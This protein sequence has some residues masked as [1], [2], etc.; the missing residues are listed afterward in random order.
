MIIWGKVETLREQRSKLERL[1]SAEPDFG[2]PPETL[3]TQGNDTESQF[4]PDYLFVDAQCGHE[5]AFEDIEWVVNMGRMDSPPQSIETLNEWNQSLALFLEYEG[6]VVGPENVR[7][8][9]ATATN[10]APNHPRVTEVA[11]ANSTGTRFFAVA[12]D[13]ALEHYLSWRASTSGE[14]GAPRPKK[15]LALVEPDVFV[16]THEFLRFLACFDAHRALALAAPRNRTHTDTGFLVLT[17]PAADLVGR[18]ASSHRLPT[19]SDAPGHALVRWCRHAGVALK[20]V[21]LVVSDT[22]PDVWLGAHVA[23]QIARGLRLPVVY[24]HVPLPQQLDYF[25][26]YVNFERGRHPHS[27]VYPKVHQQQSQ[28]Q[29]Q[30]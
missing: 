9:W 11:V 14:N 13:S 28:Q 12:A 23:D 17:Q 22:P 1:V 5:V 10:P 8:V 15:W 24:T 25:P 29:Q 21:A 2:M 3:S 19:D 30:P 26:Y 20:D 4:A 16:A 18:A 6:S 7:V 27:F